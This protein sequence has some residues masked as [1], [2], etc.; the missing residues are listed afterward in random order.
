MVLANGAV[1]LSV[2]A[3]ALG[4]EL[5]F[6]AQFLAAGGIGTTDF[7]HGSLSMAPHI[8]RKSSLSCSILLKYLAASMGMG[9]RPTI[10]SSHRGGSREGLYGAEVERKQA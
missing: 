6:H 9:A 2:T 7:F 1:W 8:G 4:G 3:H 5:V 10:P